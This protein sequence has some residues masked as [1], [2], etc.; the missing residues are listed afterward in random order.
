M[1]EKIRD[2]VPWLVAAVFL[3]GLAHQRREFGWG[4]PVSS[5]ARQDVALADGGIPD[6]GE[7]GIRGFHQFVLPPAVAADPQGALP[8]GPQISLA[9]YGFERTSGDAGHFTIGLEIIPGPGGRIDLSSPLG[10]LGVA[11]EIEGPN[12]LVG[13]AHGL[14][15][16]LDDGAARGPGGTVRIGPTPGLVYVTVPAQALCPGY[17]GTNVQQGLEAPMDANNTITGQPTYTLTVSI[18]D[19]A[20]GA[21]RASAKSSA[22]G[23]VLTAD[24]VIP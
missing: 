24:N 4:A 15:I 18:S 16:T 21:L 7:C 5:G 1:N 17:D 14:P 2:A 6:G 8:A 23:D 13:G 9:S 19:P 3:V 20:I 12:G 10:P 11:V 22:T